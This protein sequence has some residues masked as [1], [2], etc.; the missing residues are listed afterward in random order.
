LGVSPRGS[1]ALYKAAKAAAFIDER[2]YITP[3]DVK[4]CTISV[5]SHRIMLSAKGK[6]ALGTSEEAVRIAVSNV[7]VPN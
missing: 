4:N 5:L 6:A 7:S 3:D 2:D 1:I